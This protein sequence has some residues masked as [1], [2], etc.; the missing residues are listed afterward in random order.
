MAVD[1]DRRGRIVSAVDGADLGDD[2]ETLGDGAE[3]A[4]EP[5]PADFADWPMTAEQAAPFVSKEIG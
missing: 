1:P 5:G 3:P 4:L 2:M